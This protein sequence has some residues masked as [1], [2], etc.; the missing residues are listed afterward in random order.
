MKILIDKET[1][2]VKYAEENIM[3]FANISVV[4]DNKNNVK[5]IINDYNA[6]NSIIE[7]AENLPEDF[8]GDKYKFEDGEFVKNE[9]FIE[10]E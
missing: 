6:N 1:K 8:I 2:V 7:E 10:E 3:Q 9:D 4:L 5:F